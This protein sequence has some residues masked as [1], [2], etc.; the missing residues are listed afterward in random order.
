MVVGQCKVAARGGAGRQQKTSKTNLSVVRREL[1]LSL[2]FFEFETWF[3]ATNGG[4]NNHPKEYIT[5]NDR[6]INNNK[7]IFLG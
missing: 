4:I 6:D 5:N 2:H 3:P 7:R 1:K